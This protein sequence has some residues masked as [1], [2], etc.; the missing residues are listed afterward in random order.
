[1][2]SLLITLALFLAGCI[3]CT[4]T[5]PKESPFKPRERDLA[6]TLTFPDGGLCSGT[7]VARNTILTAGHCVSKDQRAMSVDGVPTMIREVILDGENNDH[8]LV[9]TNMSYREW[10]RFGRL[11]TVGDRLHIY[12]NPGGLPDL[13]REG[14]FTEYLRV[15]GFTFYL[16]DMNIWHGDSG[17]AIWNDKGQ[18]VNS[19]TGYFLERNIFTGAQWRIGVALP[20]AFTAEEW[21]RAGIEDPMPQETVLAR[22]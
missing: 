6:V 2:K 8:A 19:V 10:A 14:E 5:P 9:I 13:Y 16:F 11:P 20:F 4:S 12:G 17:A 21:A 1:M 7:P 22:P 15:D 18:V 3:G